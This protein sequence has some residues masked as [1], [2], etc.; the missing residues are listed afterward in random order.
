MKK[1]ITLMVLATGVATVSHAQLQK[2]NVLVGGDIA[3]FSLGLDK[4][5][6]FQ[7]NI[8]P[9]AAWFIKDNIAVGAY[10]GL[11]VLTAK[12]SNTETSYGVGALS[13]LLCRG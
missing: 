4:G 5:S 1:F 8:D 3:N 6:Y 10:V 13:P 2:G 7:V 11:G 12:N 9:K